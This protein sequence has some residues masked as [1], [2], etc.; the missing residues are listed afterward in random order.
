MLEALIDPKPQLQTPSRAEL[1]RQ[2]R[3]TLTEI[4]KDRWNAEIEHAVRWVQTTNWDGVRDNMEASVVRLFGGKVER[5]QDKIVELESAGVSKVQEALGK[6][7]AAIGQGKDQA[8]AGVERAATSAKENL[9]SI[10]TIDGAR[11]AVRGAVSKGI[12]KGKEV[13]GRAQAAVGVVVPP[14]SLT[15]SEVEKALQ[16]RYEKSHTLDKTV[17]EVLEER[18]KPIDSRDNSVLRGV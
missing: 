2:E 7:K 17:E 12:E 6:S 16:E 11:E 14:S 10:G 15:H 1:A 9:A 3:L 5:A 18:Y 13:V 8:I 4:A